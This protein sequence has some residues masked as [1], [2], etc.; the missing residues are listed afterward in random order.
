MP[1]LL[2]LAFKVLPP[3]WSGLQDYFQ[4]HSHPSSQTSC[5]LLSM[6][7]QSV[8]IFSYSGIIIYP[9]AWTKILG[10]ILYS[11]LPLT[12]NYQCHQ[13]LWS[14]LFSKYAPIW[15]LF[16]L[17]FAVILVQISSSSLTQV[18][19]SFSLVF[20]LQVLFS[21]AGCVAQCLAHNEPLINTCWMNGQGM[22]WGPPFDSRKQNYGCPKKQ[23]IF[24]YI[25]LAEPFIDQVHLWIQ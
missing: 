25:L 6:G 7:F 18:T 5:C 9:V 2:A 13:Q 8:F 15:P 17:P 23:L 21:I 3:S 11:S 20:L 16:V 12:P 1:R 4:G 10:V 19:T 14:I 22:S 24:Q